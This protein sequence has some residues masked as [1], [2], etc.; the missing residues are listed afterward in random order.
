MKTKF[1]TIALF[2]LMGV[3]FIGCKKEKSIF[4]VKPKHFLEDSKYKSLTVEIVYVKGQE[5]NQTALDNLETFVTERLNKPGGINFVQREIP[6]PNNNIYSA[7]DLRDL[8]NDVRNEYTESKKLAAFIFYAD[9]GYTEDNS[10]SK[11]L[12]LAYAS[13]SM[14]MLKETI[15]AN[16]GGL[17]QVNETELETAVLIHEFCHVL[18]LVNNGTPMAQNHEDVNRP[19]H[20]DNEDCLMYFESK[21]SDITGLLGGGSLPTLD[22]QCLKD[23]SEN[24]GK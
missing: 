8:E 16:S 10:N 15:D 6:S 2:L 4:D 7:S 20:C 17:G 23:L 18:G 5:P 3:T 22:A 9:Q 19:H 14:C 13:T 12:G 24:G 11:V 21:T 1:K